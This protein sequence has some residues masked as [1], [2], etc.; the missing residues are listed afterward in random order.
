MFCVFL[1]ILLVSFKFSTA[2]P[3]FSEKNL[4]LLQDS[5]VYYHNVNN[6]TIFKNKDAYFL[7]LGENITIKNV[8]DV[9]FLPKNIVFSKNGKYGMIDLNGIEIIPFVYDDL[10][11][12]KSIV[13]NKYVAN[14]SSLVKP[15]YKVETSN[16]KALVAY[17]DSLYGLVSMNGDILFETKYDKVI[18]NSVFYVSK[19]NKN[20]FSEI[21]GIYFP[22]TGKILPVEYD[23]I[24][25][26]DKDF[27]FLSKDGK[28]GVIDKMFNIKLPF[29]FE[30]IEYLSSSEKMIFKVVLEGKYGLY[31]YEGKELFPPIYDDIRAYDSYGHKGKYLLKVGDV[32]GLF[33]LNIQKMII[34]IEYNFISSADDFL[35]V[36]FKENL[37]GIYDLSGKLI[38]PV[39]FDEVYLFSEKFG[40]HYLVKK[41]NYEGIIN[42]KG[43]FL[44]EPVYKEIQKQ[45]NEYMLKPNGFI[46][47]EKAHY[48][49][50]NK[51]NK[52]GIYQDNIGQVTIP[53]IYDNIL[54]K[55]FT[56]KINYFVAV[57]NGKY[58]IIDENNNTIVSFKYDSLAFYPDALQNIVAK[59]G[60][61]YGVI[62][63]EGN[64]VVPF[65][66]SHL[67]YLAPGLFKAKK[68]EGYQLI[69]AFNKVLNPDKF[70]DL[71]LF[72]AGEAL[73]FKDGKMRVINK[74][75][76]YILS[77]VAM[78][79]HQGFTTVE[80]M[81]YALIDAMDSQSNNELRSFAEKIAPSPHILYFYEK[82]ENNH[83]EYVNRYGYT[84]LENLVDVYYKA[85][86]IIKY[87]DWNEFDVNDLL[88]PDYSFFDNRGNIT[89]TGIDPLY[90]AVFEELL[91][92]PIRINGYWISSHFRLFNLDY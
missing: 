77:E 72:E 1:S 79:P 29:K 88:Q 90:S 49:I 25:Y 75:G 39:S 2:N 41:N 52:Q 86:L 71:S 69:N 91:R 31:S 12:D 45:Y 34:P 10:Y 40:S 58:G 70:D 85:L 73:A 8:H 22:E 11:I 80:E 43:E 9:C 19:Y 57:S 48:V 78:N 84:D 53:V 92:N 55:V 59:K 33:D 4:P 23:R 61:K 50:K 47:L 54:Q 35:T 66:Y 16:P 68:N 18:F 62:N 81:K 3:I 51:E 64:I 15:V 56:G 32:I 28:F 65:E 46:N 17:K 63:Y 14:K 83:Y 37:Y 82:Q 74:D 42:A 87:N 24:S 36:V 67:A 30:R 6:A 38:L 20:D 76:T 60:T 44:L 89:S 21:Y 5:L 27:I 13:N 26:I 7:K